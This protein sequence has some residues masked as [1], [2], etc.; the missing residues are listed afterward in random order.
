MSGYLKTF[1]LLA[2][3]AY[4]GPAFSRK[5]SKDALL[6]QIRD[7]CRSFDGKVGVGILGLDFKDSLVYNDSMRFPMQSVYKVPLAIFIL[8]RVD[9]KILRLDQSVRVLKSS[10]DQN[11]WSPMLKDFK[12][13]TLNISISQLLLYSVS[14]SDN[15]ACDLLFELA[16]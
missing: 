1:L 9:Q 15:N 6:S 14:K 13:D 3:F 10:L 7:R 4:C 5:H 8:N 2:V 16:G 11:T 12:E